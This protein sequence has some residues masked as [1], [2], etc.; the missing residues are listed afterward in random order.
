MNT[1]ILIGLFFLYNHFHYVKSF[2]IPFKKLSFK[3]NIN[4]LI[5]GENE[6]GSLL[7]DQILYRTKSGK[8]QHI[9]QAERY[10][11][12]DWIHNIKTLPASE[13]LRRIRPVLIFNII[14]T[15]IIYILFKKFNFKCPGSK[16]HSLLGTALGLLL[17]FRTNTA[18]NRFWEGR[19]V[20]ENVLNSLRTLGRAVV[21]NYL[22]I[23]SDIIR[24]I[25]H[26]ICAYPIC[27]RE[28]VNGANLVEILQY[29]LT[30]EQINELS[31]V[32]NRPYHVT[33]L[34]TK[35]IMKIKL[36]DDFSGREREGMTKLLHDLTK[37]IG[38]CER[39]VQTPVPLTY[40]R[41]T[42]RFLSLFCF[43]A[44]IAFVSELGFYVILFVPLTT[45]S[46][47]GIQEIG[48]LI[49]NPFVKS[50]KL[51][52]F[53]NTIRRDISDLLHVYNTDNVNLNIESD[54]LSYQ[55]PIYAKE[56]MLSLYE[57]LVH[58]R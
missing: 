31:K 39:I 57:E 40:A 14:W 45:W 48:M 36:N 29:V 7:H 53:E 2:L 58:N 52:I 43:A 54:Y 27:L 18:Y 6:D 50:L 46:L 44:P 22:N 56:K 24:N 16:A 1:L 51:E 47:F 35:E 9:P 25:L 33:N 5:K 17:V 8:I 37:A 10:S 28:H 4:N 13:L 30:P 34:I 21:S 32:T 41:H 49:E 26:L 20:W 55:N 11:S 42:S 3:L 12:R 38:S 15:S 19:R 23:P